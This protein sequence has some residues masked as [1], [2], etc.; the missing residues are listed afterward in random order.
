MRFVDLI[1]LVYRTIRAHLSDHLSSLIGLLGDDL[2][3]MDGWLQTYNRT[4]NRNLLLGDR[5]VL[6]QGLLL[7]LSGYYGGLT[8]Y[9]DSV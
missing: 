5:N 7:N 3:L 2:R 1:D 9:G 6:G 8:W 4:H